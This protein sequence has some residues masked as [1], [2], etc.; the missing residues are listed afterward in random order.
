VIAG[1]TCTGCRTVASWAIG[2][3]EWS[4]IAAR[5]AAVRTAT[6]AQ[7][8]VEYRTPA[9]WY[10]PACAERCADTRAHRRSLVDRA[11]TLARW[12]E[13]D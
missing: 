2:Q 1:V 13:V 3:G 12:T 4:S 11:E 5:L 7:G 10:C 8:W 6:L 9:A